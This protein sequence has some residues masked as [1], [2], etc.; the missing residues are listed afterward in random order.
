MSAWSKNIKGLYGVFSK[1]EFKKLK[2]G[3]IGPRSSALLAAIDLPGEGEQTVII[4]SPKDD[5]WY[6]VRAARV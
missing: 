4:I 5:G 1:E 3:Y 6:D 2:D